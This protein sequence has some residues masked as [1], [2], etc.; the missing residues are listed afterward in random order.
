MLDV[1]LLD[2]NMQDV[3]MHNMKMYWLYYIDMLSGFIF[4]PG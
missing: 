2:M 1:K 3:K 4:S